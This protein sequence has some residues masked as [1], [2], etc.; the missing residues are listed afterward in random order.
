MTKDA[1]NQKRRDEGLMASSTDFAA[2]ATSVARTRTSQTP[3]S[4]NGSFDVDSGASRGTMSYGTGQQASLPTA[5]K[6]TAETKQGGGSSIL[7]RSQ[8][9]LKHLAHVNENNTTGK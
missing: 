9:M 8:K 6:S 5:T 1:V 2:V 7:A 3:A 4:R